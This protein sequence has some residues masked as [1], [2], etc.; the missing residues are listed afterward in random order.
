MSC[1]GPHLH[2]VWRKRAK[3]KVNV[4]MKEVKVIVKEAWILSSTVTK[5]KVWV[6]ITN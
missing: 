4:M 2:V 6:W 5:K 3:K 1:G